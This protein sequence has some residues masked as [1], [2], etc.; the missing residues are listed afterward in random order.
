MLVHRQISDTPC[1]PKHQTGVKHMIVKKITCTGYAIIVQ[2]VEHFGFTSIR[3]QLFICVGST[4]YLVFKVVAKLT[5]LVANIDGHVTAH[6]Q[7][8]D[9]TKFHMVKAPQRH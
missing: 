2:K 5:Y 4:C 1:K 9:Q 7:I 3:N 6:C 8:F